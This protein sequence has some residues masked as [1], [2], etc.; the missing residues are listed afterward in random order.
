MGNIN[1][2]YRLELDGSKPSSWLTT[3]KGIRVDREGLYVLTFTS[4]R[5]QEMFE[6][7]VE[8]RRNYNTR[9]NTKERQKY[10]K[11]NSKGES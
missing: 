4:K 11:G 9:N 3:Y 1:V 6:A 8:K 2:R 5:E 10:I 7:R